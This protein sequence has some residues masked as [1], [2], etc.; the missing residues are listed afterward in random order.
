MECGGDDFELDHFKEHNYTEYEIFFDQ[1]L[2]L[3]DFC[4]V[5]FGSYDPT[6]FG[7]KKK[8]RLDMTILKLS[9]V[10]PTYK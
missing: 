6:Y 3:C 5:D 9:E 2:V 4:D 10:F 7:F 8:R 1:R